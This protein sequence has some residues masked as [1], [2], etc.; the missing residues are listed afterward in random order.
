MGGGGSGRLPNLTRMWLKGRLPRPSL[1]LIAALESSFNIVFALFGIGKNATPSGI[2]INKLRTDSFQ[3]MT[4]LNK[5]SGK[6]LTLEDSSPN[7]GARIVQLTRSDAPNQRWFVKYAKSDRHQS[8]PRLVANEARRFWRSLPSLPQAG[9]SIIADHSGLCLS[10]LNGSREDIGA[11]QQAP[12]DG[13]RNQLWAFIP[14]N[15]GFNFIVNLY[16][17]QVLDVAD[18]SL[19]NYAAVQL[20]PFN[21]GDHQRWQLLYPCGQEK[22]LAL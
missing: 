12:F 17:G 14:D 22:R 16:N 7:Q 19:K 11:A 20:P 5:L 2:T 18:N 1:N 3:S 9:W 4:I 6:A 21:G 15:N 8:T 13:Q 10:I